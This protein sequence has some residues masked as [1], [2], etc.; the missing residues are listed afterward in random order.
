MNTVILTLRLSD[1]EEKQHKKQRIFNVLVGE[2]I[3]FKMALGC[4]I[5]HKQPNFG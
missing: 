3:E 4:G 1:L 5:K 2:T